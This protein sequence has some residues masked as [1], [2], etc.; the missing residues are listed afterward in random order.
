MRRALG[1][2]RWT[3]RNPLREQRDRPRVAPQPSAG[4]GRGAPAA[5]GA[6][7]AL[8]LALRLQ[9]RPVP[10]AKKQT[11]LREHRPPFS[12]T[13]VYFELK[14]QPP[15]TRVWSA[16]PFVL[17][18]GGSKSRN[19]TNWRRAGGTAL[20][21][22]PPGLAPPSRGAPGL[23]RGRSPEPGG[24]Q[25]G[26]RYRHPSR[27]RGRRGSARRWPPRIAPHRRPSPRLSGPAGA[28]QR[29]EAVPGPDTCAFLLASRLRIA[30]S[31]PLT[32][33]PAR[34]RTFNPF[35]SQVIESKSQRS[36]TSA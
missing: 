28:P 33:T 9:L 16:S 27:A 21:C 10:D 34:T 13:N 35:P 12:G 3:R 32:P 15:L 14:P 31:S 1:T 7:P 30:R 8:K 11:G 18:K 24:S 6:A 25:L 26:Q 20:R 23:P 17:C 5:H 36:F 29:A 4:K 22:L 2:A 19:G